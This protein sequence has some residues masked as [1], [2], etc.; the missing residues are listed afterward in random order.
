MCGIAGILNLFEAAPVAVETIAQM[1][2]SIQHRGPDG[3]GIY[4]DEEVA[5]GSVRLSI[6]DLTSGDQPISNE[7]G[8]LWIVY[9]GEV[10]NYVELRP[11]LEKRG[12]RFTT[13]TDTEVILHLYEEEGPDCLRHLNGQFA[14]AIWDSRQHSL[15]LARDRVGVRPLFY[16]AQN[17]QLFF[18]SEIKAILAS[19]KVEACIDPQAL[20]E[21]FT[22]W[23]P[24]SPH[25]IFQGIQ[26]LPPGHW[27]IARNGQISITPY[28]HLD[29]MPESQARTANDYQEELEALLIDATRIR[30]RAD[31]PVGAYLSGGL[32]SSITTA[33][34]QTYNKNHLNTFSISFSDPHFDESVYQKQMA[35]HLGT[36][37]HVIYCN[38]TDISCA[39]PDVIWHTETPILR[40]APVPMFLL[41]QLVRDHPLKVV[42]T[43]EGADEFL[44]GYDIFKEMKIRRFWATNPDSTLRPKLLGQIYPDIRGM[45]ASSAFLTGFFKQDLTQTA[46][47][48]YS[49]LVRWRNTSRIWRFF[50]SLIAEDFTFSSVEPPPLTL[51]ADFGAWPPLSQAQYLEIV[52]FL[53]PYLLSS[54]GD[55]MAMAHSV[56]GRYPFLDYR[57]MEFC[58]RLPPEMKMPVLIEKWLLK[59]LGRKYLPDIIWRRGKRPYRAPIHRSFFNPQPPEYVRELLSPE[60]VA[61]AGYFEPDAVQKLARKA[62]AAFSGSVGLSEVE[63]MALVGILSTQL[64][65]Q[66]FIQQRNIPAREAITDHIKLVDRLSAHS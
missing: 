10:F 23:S 6:L 41:S 52:T 45:G 33:I 55:R 30:L 31:V 13:H 22:Y 7:D 38:Y 20:R 17:G 4:R 60:A 24:L 47:S 25:S 54:Q 2:E 36:D 27:M 43:G 48:F 37:H 62:G 61:A 8:A 15:F 63:D 21:V 26:E 64:V 65:H 56:E 16:S 11:D 40:T 19:G 32:D 44:A 51:P 28:W 57:V 42:L 29:F 9:N 49:H 66:M 3:T 39:F 18:G 12:H 5:L 59:Q 14:L 53:S 34:I 35:E 58:N 50:N 1:V 46:S